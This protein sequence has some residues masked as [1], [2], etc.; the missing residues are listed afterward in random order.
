MDTII[1]RFRGTDMGIDTIFEH[2]KIVNDNGYVWWGWW[3][4][5]EEKSNNKE[6]QDLRRKISSNEKVSIGIFDRTNNLFFKTELL[7]LEYNFKKLKE[8]PEKQYTPSYYNNNKLYCWFKISEIIKITENEFVTQFSEIPSQIKTLY[9][10]PLA[11]SSKRNFRKNIDS[12][13]ILHLSDI[14]FGVDFGFPDSATPDNTPLIDRLKSYFEFENKIK[15]GLVIISGDITSRGDA[16]IL[17]G[18][19]TNFLNSLCEILEIDKDQIIIVPG[20][21][22]IPLK[23]ADFH[24]Y[25]HEAAYKNFLKSFYNEDK[26]LS[27]I[28]HFVTN[29]GLE[30]DILRINSVRLRT[31]SEMNYG[32]VGWDDYRRIIE[33][34]IHLNSKSIKI[35]VLHHHLLPV[36]NEEQIDPDS[37]FSSVSVTLDSGKV[38]EGLQ[39]YNFSIVLH[40]H[41]H[42]PGLNKVARGI[43][44]D[45]KL[46]LEKEIFLIGAGSAGA[47]IERLNGHMR[48]NS[49]SILK[50]E[51]GVLNLEALRYN[52]NK[53]PD[54]LFKS[55][56]HF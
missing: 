15:I 38:I 56:I 4:K 10:L 14:H 37:E 6:L 12:N 46:L 51:K 28:D 5:K 43:K 3:K 53:T 27:G 13:Y 8:S 24:D 33:D 30:I 21:H 11:K 47:R 18:A 20:N 31:K 23:N 41:Q 34:T 49:F 16:N 22:D 39:N 55:E 40:G 44:L 50:I 17:F 35:A 25:S 42:V 7:D 32:F 48:D 19:A 2:N 52:C 54:T 45:S 26:S 36:P 9:V 29:D 1:L